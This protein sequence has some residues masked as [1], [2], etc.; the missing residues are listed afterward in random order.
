[1]SVDATVETEK[2]LFLRSLALVSPP[3]SLMR[4][5]TRLL[6]HAE[7]PAGS[8]LFEQ[9]ASSGKIYFVV[10]GRVRLSAPDLPDWYLNEGSVVGV[11][12]ALQERPHRRTAVA[13]SLVKAL[14]IEASTYLEL[15]WDDFEHAR[16][17]ICLFAEDTWAK[18]LELPVAELPRSETRSVWHGRAELSPESLVDRIH[19]LLDAEPFCHMPIQP[20]VLLALHSH[21]V[22][23]ERGQRF[24]QQGTPRDAVWVVASGR[25]TLVETR[26]SSEFGP[27]QTVGGYGALAGPSFLF[28]AQALESARLLV[29][30][31]ED[32]LDVMEEHPSALRGLMHYNSVSRERVMNQLAQ[33]GAPLARGPG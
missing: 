15:L 7:Y 26:M 21:F 9:G 28:G 29:L 14:S 31:F 19:L 11:L 3:E 10:Q 30:P 2:E 18:N 17:Q 13:E 4:A 20:L 24:I 25:V 1:M 16:A 22:E 32:L 23:V 27:R 8:T 5:F 6:R 33:Q 12:D